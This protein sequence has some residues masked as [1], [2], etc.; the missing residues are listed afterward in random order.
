MIRRLIAT[1]ILLAVGAILVSPGA[2]LDAMHH[3]RHHDQIGL[4][5]R[6]AETTSVLLDSG[7]EPT[8][9]PAKTTLMVGFSISAMRC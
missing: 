9:A 8:V 6:T 3:Q 2:G 7:Y 4:V 5:A 1:A